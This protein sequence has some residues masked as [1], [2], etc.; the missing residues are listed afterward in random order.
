VAKK[1]KEV[2]SRYW[3][4]LPGLTLA[5]P[6]PV[7]QPNI[8]SLRED[9]LP[10]AKRTSSAV[11]MA[12][13]HSRI[14]PFASGNPAG[15]AE[16]PPVG[17]PVVAASSVRKEQVRS[18]ESWW[19]LAQ[20]CLGKGSRWQELWRMNPGLSRNPGWLAA[21][22][23]VV[24]PGLKTAQGSPP[25]PRIIVQAGDTLWSLAREQLG[26]AQSWPA[27]AVANPQVTNYK[28]LQIGTKLRFSGGQQHRCAKSMHLSERN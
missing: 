25:G 4:E 26:C 23:M 16:V 9:E 11:P 19:K 1:E 20:R 5:E 15:P 17:S 14:S 2:K 8:G 13:S 6:K 21:G 7:V 22:T 27:L 10:T 28:K 18:G 12:S 24:V 3:L